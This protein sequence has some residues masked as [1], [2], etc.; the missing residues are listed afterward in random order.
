M[1]RSAIAVLLL[2]ASV[3]A[4]AQAEGYIYGQSGTSFNSIG[5]SVYGSDGTSYNQIGNSRPMAPMA[6]PLRALVTPHTDL[7]AR[8]VR[9]SA[10]RCTTQT[11]PLRPA[12]ATRSTVPMELPVAR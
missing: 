7:T 1:K 3:S 9:R 11:V 10:T 12:L 2:V 6:R 4:A 8:L 5:T